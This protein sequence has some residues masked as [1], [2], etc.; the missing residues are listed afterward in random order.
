MSAMI[1]ST[2][3][4]SHSILETVNSLMYPD[5][6]LPVFAL[7]IVV[8]LDVALPDITSKSPAHASNA[9]DSQ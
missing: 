8:F 2:S 3:S 1:F 6:I 7:A 5:M 9:T 4:T